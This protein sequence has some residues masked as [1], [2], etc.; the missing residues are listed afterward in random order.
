MTEHVLT[1]MLKVRYPKPE[2]ALLSQVR[3]GTGYTRRVTRT[4]DAMALGLYPS[5]GIHLHGFEIKVSRA[6][7]KRELTEPDKAE[8]ICRF[9]EFWWIV[10]PAEVV[11]GM[12]LPPTWGVLIPKD[13]KLVIQKQGPLLSPDPLDKPFIASLF[14]SA[15]ECVAPQAE[16]DAAASISREK[17]YDEGLEVGKTISGQLTKRIGD[18]ESRIRE[19][20]DASGIRV[21][22]WEGRNFR[23]AMKFYQEGEVTGAMQK[24]ESLADAAESIASRV[25][26]ILE[27]QKGQPYLPQQ[28]PEKP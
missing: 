12:E 25:R 15:Q 1:A 5:R 7:L 19:F 3:N 10:A 4:A 14:R 9:C 18:L 13:G 26:R 11:S 17:G 20:E 23:E 8:S 2:W 28:T 16:M 27:T 21:A 24:L 6:D 22:A